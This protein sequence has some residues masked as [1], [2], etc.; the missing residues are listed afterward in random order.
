VYEFVHELVNS[1]YLIYFGLLTGDKYNIDKIT[2][3]RGVKKLVI[4]SNQTS[5]LR[6]IIL[7]QVKEKEAHGNNLV[8]EMVII[9][10]SYK[11]YHDGSYTWYI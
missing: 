4:G 10:K 11:W 6:Q 5:K 8:Q 2:L 7:A 3:A 9:D 1:K